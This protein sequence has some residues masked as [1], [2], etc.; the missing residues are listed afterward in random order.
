M[1]IHL[2]FSKQNKVFVVNIHKNTAIRKFSGVKDVP[3]PGVVG[4][5]LRRLA[6]DDV[7]SLVAVNR[8]V[9]QESLK[10]CIVKK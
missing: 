10:H 5:W 6:S 8:H 2:N 1:S 3:T 9:L 7:R 4:D